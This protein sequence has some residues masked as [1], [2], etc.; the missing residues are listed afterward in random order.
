MDDW[1]TYLQYQPEVQ[2]PEKFDP[3]WPYNFKWGVDHETGKAYVW[4]VA[5]GTDGRPSHRAE[6]QKLIGRKPMVSQGDSLGL[7]TYIPAEMRLDGTVVAPPTVLVETYYGVAT[8]EAVFAW[9][10]ENVPGVSVRTAVIAQ[11]KLGK[12]EH[13]VRCYCDQGPPGHMRSKNCKQDPGEVDDFGSDPKLYEIAPNRDFDKSA[14]QWIAQNFPAKR[15]TSKYRWIDRWIRRTAQGADH[16]GAMVALYIPENVGNEIKVKGG[17]PVDDLHITLA[18]FTDAAADRNDWDEAE[19]I[20]EQFSKQYDAFTGKVG[21]FGVF[22]QP[23]GDVLWATCDIPG[24][25]EFRHELVEALEDAGFN[26]SKEHSFTPH[27][28]LKY[29]HDGKLPKLK[30]ETSVKFDALYLT[31]AKERNEHKFT[32]LGLTKTL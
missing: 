30:K 18:Y 27:I 11:P 25:N 10:Y 13:V 24:I 17:E 32:G 26:V 15:E 1:D 9:F 2:S 23:D 4:R 20:V 14:G 21:G 3:T 7:A 29:E 8:P 6:I 22:H 12:R 31:V 16:D 19:K 5:G 28:T